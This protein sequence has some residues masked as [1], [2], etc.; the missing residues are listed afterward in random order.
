MV[1]AW[2]RRYFRHAYRNC[3]NGG[4]TKF[5]GVKNTGLNNGIRVQSLI[6]VIRA[7]VFYV[8]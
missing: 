5:A 3:F 4:F 8:F 1:F 2:Y 6:M 7:S